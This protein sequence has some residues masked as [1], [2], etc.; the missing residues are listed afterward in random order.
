M[1]LRELSPAVI[2]KYFEYRSPISLK[3]LQQREKYP[4]LQIRITRCA[5][6]MSEVERH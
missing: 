2:R 6:R 5:E 4:V 1:T 3:Q